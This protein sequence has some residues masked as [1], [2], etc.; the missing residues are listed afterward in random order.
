LLQLA[1]V[2]LR[3][4]LF[5]LRTA[6]SNPVGLAIYRSEDKV[7]DLQ[8]SGFETRAPLWS[9]PKLDDHLFYNTC[10]GSINEQAPDDGLSSQR[11]RCLEH[12]ELC[13][14]FGVLGYRKVHSLVQGTSGRALVMVIHN[15]E[16]LRLRRVSS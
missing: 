10:M 5:G 2:R 7:T 16:P 11:H 12:R 8:T 3:I 14:H 15:S 1:S 4:I 9:L 13:C 6:N